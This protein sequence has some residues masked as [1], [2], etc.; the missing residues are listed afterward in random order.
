MS[1]TR[2]L[3]LNPRVENIR[4]KTPIRIENFDLSEIKQHFI[5]NLNSLRKHFDLADDLVSSGK[6]DEAKDIWRTQIVFLESALDFYMHEITKFGMNK[7]FNCEWSSTDRFKNYTLSLSDVM[8]AISNPEDNSW[9][10]EHVN[11]KIMNE[12]FMSHDSI[13]SQL[14]LI[15]INISDVSDRAFNTRGCSTPTRSA[16]KQN[17]NSIF[18]RRNHIVHQ[19]DRSHATGIIN[20]ITK[21]YV[22]EKIEVIEKIVFSIHYFL[23]NHEIEVN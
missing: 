2:N 5:E 9:F 11:N 10:G 1:K 21:E 16:I 23:E 19:S 22:T 3:K 20:D 15:G 7:I 8:H 18:I 13:K 12:A 17:L 4:D 6:T 14:H